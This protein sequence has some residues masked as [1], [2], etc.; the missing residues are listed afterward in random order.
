MVS[1]VLARFIGGSLILMIKSA[2]RHNEG[3]STHGVAENDTVK[4]GELS[5]VDAH[6][7]TIIEIY[8]ITSHV[9]PPRAPVRAAFGAIPQPLILCKHRG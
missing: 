2:H 3:T 9:P 6:L 4:G 1:A 8:G 7:I 5:A